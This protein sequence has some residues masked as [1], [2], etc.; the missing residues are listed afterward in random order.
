M[1]TTEE[2]FG[3]LP[4]IVLYT[5]FLTFKSVDHKNLKGVE[6]NKSDLVITSLYYS[7]E[8]H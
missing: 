3:V 1:R 7:N 8:S 6:S 5:F 4:S 2:Y